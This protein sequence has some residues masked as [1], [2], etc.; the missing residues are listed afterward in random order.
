MIDNNIIIFVYPPRILDFSAQ[1]WHCL[2][3][4]CALTPRQV[5]EAF[6]L[7]GVK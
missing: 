4:I 2:L 1:I 6:L 5:Q 3:R 7:R